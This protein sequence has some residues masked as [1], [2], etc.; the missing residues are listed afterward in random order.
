MRDHVVHLA[1]DAGALGRRREL[2]L[3]IA[4][5]GQLGREI[6]EG[7]EVS[8][9]TADRLA[10]QDRED[11]PDHEPGVVLDEERGDESVAATTATSAP[12]V[13]HAASALR[14]TAIE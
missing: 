4:F 2:C 14:Y 11:D 10:D 3:L 12:E 6:D 7:S 9:P 1:G 8:A 13:I 5:A